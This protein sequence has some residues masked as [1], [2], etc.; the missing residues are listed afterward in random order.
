MRPHTIHIHLE[1]GGSICLQ[2]VDI[3]WEYDISLNPE[4]D[5]LKEGK[6]LLLF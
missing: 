1:G 6:N 3:H 5:S 4:K 2:N